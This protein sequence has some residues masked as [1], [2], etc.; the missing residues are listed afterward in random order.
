MKHL[1]PL[2]LEA[3]EK[4]I[5]T[6]QIPTDDLIHIIMGTMRFQMYKWRVANFEFDILKSGDKMIQSLLTLIKNKK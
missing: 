1:K 4:K 2:V 5:F 6:N 3:Q